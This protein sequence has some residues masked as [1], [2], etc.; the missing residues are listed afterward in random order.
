[1]LS[2]GLGRKEQQ[3]FGSS[4]RDFSPVIICSLTTSETHLTNFRGE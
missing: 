1:M 3:T 2:E 4:R